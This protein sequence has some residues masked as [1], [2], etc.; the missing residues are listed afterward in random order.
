[1]N[2]EPPPIRI[3]EF[4]KDGPIAQRNAVERYKLGIIKIIF[5]FDIIIM[6]FKIIIK[7]IFG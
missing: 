6:F 3:T 5:G 4:T 2:D 7:N 1:M